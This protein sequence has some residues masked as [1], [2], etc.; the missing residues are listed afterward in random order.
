ML[1]PQTRRRAAIYARFSTDMQR[2]KSIE[3]Q[4]DLCRKHA[5]RLN[6]E[7]VAVYSDRARS[8][9]SLMG[10]DGVLDMIS[11][12]RRGE[13]DAVIVEALDRLSRDQED[14]AGIY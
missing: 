14:L 8:G 11:A 1:A 13:F 7:V 4:V 5:D 3:D 2:D 10:R 12:S 9:A 6:C